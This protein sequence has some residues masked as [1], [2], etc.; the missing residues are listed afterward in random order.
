MYTAKHA[1]LYRHKVHGG[2]AMVFYMDIRAAGK[3]YEEFSAAGDRGGR[4]AIYLRGRVCRL[5]RDGDMVKV[6][7]FDTLCGEQVCIDADMV[8]LATAIRPQPGIEELAQ[9]LSVS[10][11]RRVHQRG[12]P[13]AAAG[14]D[15]HRRHLRRRSLPGAARHPGFGGDGQRRR[16]EGAGPVQLETS[17]SASPPWPA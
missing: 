9:K 12:A 10:T 13:E 2:Q 16:A 6:R 17:W 11:T 14:R 7:G 8:V 4:R 15:E 5:Y 1:M 3:G